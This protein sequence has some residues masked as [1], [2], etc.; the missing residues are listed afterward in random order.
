MN[1]LHSEY[2]PDGVNGKTKAFELAR[3]KSPEEIRRDIVK[4]TMPKA[5]RDCSRDRRLAVGAKWL[6]GVISDLTFLDSFGGDGEGRVSISLRDLE[7]LFHHRRDTMQIWRDALIGT[8]WIWYVERWPKAQWG[9]CA[10]CRQPELFPTLCSYPL[11]AFEGGTVEPASLPANRETAKTGQNGPQIRPGGTVE[12]ATRDGRTGQRG[13]QNRP[14]GTV[15]PA[16]LAR[17]NRPGGTV[18]PANGDGKT[19]QCGPVEPAKGAGSTVHNRSL[20][21]SK[22][23]LKSEGEGPTPPPEAAQSGKNKEE[24]AFAAWRTSLN[25]RYPSKLENLRERLRAQ[26]REA[27]L[28][29]RNEAQ[30]LLSRKIGVLDEL[31]DGPQPAWEKSKGPDP[32]QVRVPAA[33]PASEAELLEGARFL[34]ESRKTNLL[35][36]GQ[37]EALAR[38]GEAI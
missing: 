4:S 11:G 24:E 17:K 8:G 5:R 37:R 12:P 6:F 3:P 34:V 15:E 35:T 30:A 32:R 2:L 25:G 1:D 10:V 7:R 13:R 31:L 38:A 9:I 19:G 29:R 20:L 33:T 28:E 23:P 26:R 14:Q 18:D 16:S 27:R 21:R 22:E 36:A